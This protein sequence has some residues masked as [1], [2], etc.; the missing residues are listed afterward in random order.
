M[1]PLIFTSFFSF[2]LLL[3]L[4]IAFSSSTT[5]V[6]HEAFMSSV[7]AFIREPDDLFVESRI[8][9]PSLSSSV[10]PSSSSSSSSLLS[11]S[12]SSSSSSSVSPFPSTPRLAYVISG[13]KGD[14]LQARRTLLALYHPRNQYVL[15]LD[16]EAS[17]RERVDLIRFVKLHPTFSQ[18]DNVHVISKSN[19]VTYKG[20][21]MVASTLHAAAILLKKSKDWDWFINLSSSDYPLVT[22]DG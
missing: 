16:R 6:P 4:T 7:L 19:L 15:H 9:P 18:F 8:P 22:Q 1:L 17:P 2:I 13:S 14:G 12:S 5:N 10:A 3:L 20:P 21:T 11:S